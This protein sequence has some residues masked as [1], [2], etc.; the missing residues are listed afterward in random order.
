LLFAVD[1][2]KHVV[3][4]LLIEQAIHMVFTGETGRHVFFVP[5]QAI[6]WGAGN[7]DALGSR[8]AA[9]NADEIAFS[10]AHLKFG[11][12]RDSSTPHALQKAQVMLRR[13]TE[14]GDWRL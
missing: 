14:S 2:R 13:M 10:F 6:L 5:E 3:K 12:S 4:G 8:Q 9:H 7:V 1:G 11:G